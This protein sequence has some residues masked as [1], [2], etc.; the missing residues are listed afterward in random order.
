MNFFLG[1]VSGLFLTGSIVGS[2][3][4]YPYSKKIFDESKTQN[5]PNKFLSYYGTVMTITGISLGTGFAFAL[6]P[7][8]IPTIMLNKYSSNNKSVSNMDPIDI[9]SISK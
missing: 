2:Y 4:A 3:V 9:I 1:T 6:S 8:I 7:I 5:L